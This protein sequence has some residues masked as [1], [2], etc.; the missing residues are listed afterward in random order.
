MKH[1][2][3]EVWQP[4][5]EVRAGTTWSFS[6]CAQPPRYTNAVPIP[7]PIDN[8]DLHT[9]VFSGAPPP[10]D[11]SAVRLMDC[12]GCSTDSGCGASLVG[13]AVAQPCDDPLYFPDL[14]LAAG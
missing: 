2:R 7:R 6:P 11:P 8:P 3:G 4:Q 13:L 12:F 10:V 9:G 1:T 5:F 14:L